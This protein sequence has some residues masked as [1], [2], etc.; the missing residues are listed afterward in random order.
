[1]LHNCFMLYLDC[2]IFILYLNEYTFNGDEHEKDELAKLVTACL[3]KKFQD[4]TCT[5]SRARFNKGGCPFD[6]FFKQT[7][8]KLSY[9]NPYNLFQFQ[10]R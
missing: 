5:C 4:I 2:S 8:L 9:D 1:M 10:H 7:P 6:V 3:D